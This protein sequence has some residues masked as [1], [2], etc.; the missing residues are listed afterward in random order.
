MARGS[1]RKHERSGGKPYEVVVDLGQDPVTGKRRQR[2]KSFKTKREAQ[3]ALTAWLSE[4]DR[5]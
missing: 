5:E 2:S 1:I 4:I 3:A